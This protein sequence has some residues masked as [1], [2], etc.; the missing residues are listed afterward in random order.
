MVAQSSPVVFSETDG[1][2][3]SSEI[4]GTHCSTAVA[5]SIALH[6]LSDPL[7]PT[8][9]V[10]GNGNGGVPVSQGESLLALLP[11]LVLEV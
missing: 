4:D 1:T 5:S 9:A 7:K 11:V 10:G 6:V 2:H 8:V 3:C